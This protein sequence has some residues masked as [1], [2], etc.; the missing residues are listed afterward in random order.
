MNVHFCLII[1]FYQTAIKKKKIKKPVSLAVAT[2]VYMSFPAVLAVK[3]II[4]PP[5]WFD[6]FLCTF[7]RLMKF[8]GSCLL[9]NTFR[10]S[11]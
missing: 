1:P 9:R 8:V 6:P 3:L 7:A 2:A 5:S 11:S 4:L 10:S